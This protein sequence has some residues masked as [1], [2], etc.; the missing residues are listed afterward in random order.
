MNAWLG[1]VSN[2]WEF[3]EQIL[4]WDFPALNNWGQVLGSLQRRYSSPFPAPWPRRSYSRNTP[5]AAAPFEAP[6]GKD[7]VLFPVPRANRRQNPGKMGEFQCFWEGIPLENL[8]GAQP[9][10]TRAGFSLENIPDNSVGFD[11]GI[12][13]HF[14]KGS[15]NS[16][17]RDQEFHQQPFGFLREGRSH[18]WILWEFR[19][20][21]GVPSM[22][23]FLGFAR[24][25]EAAAL[26]PC[27]SHGI[28]HP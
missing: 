23:A 2:P 19:F 10:I 4:G 22:P 17:Q 26:S 5:V 16:S 25:K 27:N 7:S 20:S 11:L 15:V 9:E 28:L 1:G 14:P 24:E 12:D 13:P 18:P 6:G 8:W 21:G 3:P